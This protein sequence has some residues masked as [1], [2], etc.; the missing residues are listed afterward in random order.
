MGQLACGERGDAGARVALA[1]DLRW[2]VDVLDPAD[3]AFC[4]GDRG[5]RD[6]GALHP[7]TNRSP[8]FIRGLICSP[9]GLFTPASA[10]NCAA[11]SSGALR[12]PATSGSP[13]CISQRVRSRTWIAGAGPVDRYAPCGGV[14][15][16]AATTS[17]LSFAQS[18]S[19]SQRSGTASATVSPRWAVAT[20]SNTLCSTGRSRRNAPTRFRN[21]RESLVYRGINPLGVFPVLMVAIVS[22]EPRVA[23][24]LCKN[25]RMDEEMSRLDEGVTASTVD[26]D[27]AVLQVT[28]S[29]WRAQP[30]GSTN[31][32]AFASLSAGS[33]CQAT[34]RCASTRWRS[35]CRPHEPGVLGLR[36]R[37]SAQR[38]RRW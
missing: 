38:P 12:G 18:Q 31:V 35:T 28:E 17:P 25:G 23:L 32:G 22:G 36:R 20:P 6:R 4:D 1:A 8:A 13:G 15:C 37:F 3:S 19:Q 9:E 30:G 11:N 5:H 29:D 24:P 21:F 27:V 26:L 33:R 2:G 16:A 14:C 7:Q 10:T 34:R